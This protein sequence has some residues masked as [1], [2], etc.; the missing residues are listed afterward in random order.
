[1]EFK[2]KRRKLKVTI[3]KDSHEVRF[4]WQGELDQ[5]LSDVAEKPE[6]T[7]ELH[8]Q[9]LAKLGLPVEAQ[10]VLEPADLKEIVRLLT[11]QKNA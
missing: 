1:M 10:K 4:P 5:Y 3:D 8:D 6:K 9:F 11:D 2:A 7:Q